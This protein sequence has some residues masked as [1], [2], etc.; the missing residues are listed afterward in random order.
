MYFTAVTQTPR[1]A[2][3]LK[4]LPTT[5]DISEGWGGNILLGAKQTLDHIA[6]KNKT[7]KMLYKTH[8]TETFQ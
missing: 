8:V 5:L 4:P 6:D 3:T 7:G 1:Q 2:S